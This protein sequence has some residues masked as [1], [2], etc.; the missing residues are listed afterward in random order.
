M[1]NTS[2]KSSLRLPNYDYTTPGAYF[3]T[4]TAS[5]RRQVFGT[6]E[7]GQTVLSPFGQIA[8]ACIRALPDHFGHA[9]VDESVVMPDH[10][11]VIIL[12]L[13]EPENGV[14]ARHALHEQGA[15]HGRFGRPLPGSLPTIVGSLKSAITRRVNRA[16]GTPGAQLWKRN[17]NEHVIRDDA[18]LDSI[19]QYIRNN[20]LLW[21]LEQQS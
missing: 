9:A 2:P 3:V 11:H 14:R 15:R 13:T 7:N 4:M 6:I 8:V 17:Y 19:R 18:S 20:P 21:S 12:I 1:A 5:P 16:R 10:V